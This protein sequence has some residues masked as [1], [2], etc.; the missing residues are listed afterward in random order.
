MANEVAVRQEVKTVRAALEQ[1]RPQLEMALPKHLPVDRLVRVAM[2]SIQNT[3][4]LLECDRQSL[5]SAVMTCAQLGLEPDGVLGQA[6]LIPYGRQ[7]QFI[8]GYRGL[9]TLARNSGEVSSIMAQCVHE[10]DEFRYAFGLKAELHHVP[11]RGD[12]GAITHVYAIAQFKDGGHHWDVMSVE[13]VEMIRDGSSGYQSAKKWAKNGQ[14]NSPWVQ[15]FEEMAKKTAIRRI[16]KY[17]PM[18]VQRAAFI[19]ASYDT[20]Q[21]SEIDATGE[22]RVVTVPDEPEEEPAALEDSST[23]DSFAGDEEPAEQVHADPSPNTPDAEPED[24]AEMAQP[25]LP[26]DPPEPEPKGITENQ[27]QTLAT[28]SAKAKSA[29]SLD[30]WLGGE[31]IKATVNRMSPDQMRSWT[32]HLTSLRNKL[33][34]PLYEESADDQPPVSMEYGDG[35]AEATA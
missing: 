2:T 11:A 27:M 25:A 13:E 1:M 23:L 34:P 21:H 22:L 24:G 10:R 14:I 16:A 32:N 35:G 6:Y 20:G 8:P 17:L 19:A 29:E 4:K 18:D 15:H 26:E 9:I 5:F 28:N 7:V 3:P 12:R 33:A 30:A 31:R